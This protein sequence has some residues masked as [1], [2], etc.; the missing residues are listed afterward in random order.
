M[1]GSI[2]EAILS[3]RVPIVTNVGGNAEVI[4][5]DVT[6]FVANAATEDEI[7]EAM[8]RALTAQRVARDW[9]SGSDEDPHAGSV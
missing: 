7:D 3:G 2:V 8:E 9:R 6:G 4:D 1:R 5:D